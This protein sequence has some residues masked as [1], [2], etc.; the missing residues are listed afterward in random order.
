MA[1]VVAWDRFVRYQP[2]AGVEV[3]YG[4]PILDATQTD[5][6]AELAK[7]GILEV[8]IL[9]GSSPFDATPT[10]SREKVGKLL[11]PLT[12]GDVPI[13][14]CIGLNYKTHS[15]LPCILDLSTRR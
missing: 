5:E 7:N 10:G 11:G 3:R 13:V 1:K 14:R 12:A 4:Q 9:E 2:V 15:E 6:V 8:E